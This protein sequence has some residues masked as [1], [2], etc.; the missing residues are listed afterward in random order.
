MNG[1]N[2]INLLEKI[3]KIREEDKNLS[4]SL[5]NKK[6][7]KFM[8]A[9]QM[10]VKKIKDHQSKEIWDNIP[11][12]Y[13]E[14]ME[15]E[16]AYVRELE[17]LG[18]E[19]YN[20]LKEKNPNIIKYSIVMNME[21]EDGTKV[22]KL[23]YFGVAPER[24]QDF[25]NTF[26]ENGKYYEMSGGRKPFLIEDE[27]QKKKLTTKEIVDNAL[28]N[29]SNNAIST[30]QHLQ[31]EIQFAVQNNNA[32]LVDN[33]YTHI[34]N[35]E[36]IPESNP[37]NLPTWQLRYYDYLRRKAAEEV[38]KAADRGVEYDF[39]LSKGGTV[40]TDPRGI[41]IVPGVYVD[42]VTISDGPVDD[43]IGGLIDSWF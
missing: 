2:K 30:M 25:L 23:V 15:I 26:N 1:D 39:D 28:N 27:K 3:K 9:L 14:P 5:K 19:S 41:E 18:L 21:Q 16:E 12:S 7:I 22:N 38:E 42:E 33:L 34:S 11:I 6:T 20:K 35:L 40:V 29:V 32:I 4:F 43:I 31:N 36:E 13:F 17:V 8:K 24:E 10:Q 37:Y